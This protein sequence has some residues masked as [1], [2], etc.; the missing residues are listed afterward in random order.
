MTFV[1]KSLTSGGGKYRR[2]AGLPV[3]QYY[4]GK[5]MWH[6]NGW[7]ACRDAQYIHKAD[8]C[9]GRVHVR[10]AAQLRCLALVGTAVEANPHTRTH[11]HTKRVTRCTLMY[12]RRG[13]SAHALTTPSLR[14]AVDLK[15]A[16]WF[17]LLGK[18]GIA[19]TGLTLVTGDIGTSPIAAETGITGFDL[20]QDAI[21]SSRPL[22]WSKARSLPQITR[23][24]RQPL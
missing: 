17:A 5:T 20:S 23:R 9:Y 22:R 3:V 4:P 21:M 19:T 2:A 6:R 24:P 15:T 14:L 11:T 8:T 16:G 1:I 10:R 13:L 7:H 18:S 12:K